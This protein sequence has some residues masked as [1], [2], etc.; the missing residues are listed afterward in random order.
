[1][2]VPPE[3]AFRNLEPTD[4]LKA[5]I[6]DGIA[7]LESLYPDLISCRTVVKDDTPGQERGKNIRVRLE[8][9]IPGRRLVVE[10]DNA[11]PATDRDVGRTLRD[12]FK[13]AEK[14]LKQAKAQQRGDVKTHGLPPHGRI[15]RLLADDHGVRYG[16][17]ESRDG[18]QVYFHENALVGVDFHELEVGDEVLI[19]VSGGDQGLQ[20][21][22]VEPIPGPG[23]GPRQQGS[24]PLEG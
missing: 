3:I 13:I 8:V 11:N 20:A 23:M 12:A 4:D 18:E 17:I 9:A 2:Q 6:R 16:Y 5:L 1:M 14:R 10:E 22:T 19:A 24:V 21:S 15:V 7:G